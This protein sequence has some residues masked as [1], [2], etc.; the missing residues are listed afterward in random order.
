M[1]IG[2]DLIEFVRRSYL[3]AIA[4]SD[5]DWEAPRAMKAGSIGGKIGY[6]GG[7]EGRLRIERSFWEASTS[8][9]VGWWSWIR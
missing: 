9:V 8:L 1:V 7:G 3:A 2:G 6:C 5:I 4:E